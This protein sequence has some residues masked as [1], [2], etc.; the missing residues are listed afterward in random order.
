[1]VGFSRKSLT[2]LNMAE[3][4]PIPSASTSTAVALNPGL[5]ASIRAPNFKS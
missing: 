4:A 3:F 2:R 1:M 5:R